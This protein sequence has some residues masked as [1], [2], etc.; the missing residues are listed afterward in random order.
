[1]NLPPD[2]S[3]VHTRT[4]DVLSRYPKR[5]PPLP[6]AYRDIY[7]QHY[8]ANRLASYHTT[9]LSQRLEAWMHHQVASDLTTA[10]YVSTLE[11]GAGTLNHL[12]FA[13]ATG[14]YDIVEP[15]AKLYEDSPQLARIGSIYQ[16]IRDV[17]MGKTYD[18]IVSIATFEHLLDL[19]AVVAETTRLLAPGGTLRVA[20][21]NEGTLLWRL[22]TCVTGTEFRLRYG[23]NYQVLMRHEH[24][25]TAA[26]VKAVLQHAYS[27]LRDVA[28][29]VSR[30]LALYRF[31][32]CRR[33]VVPH[34]AAA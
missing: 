33:P 8:V 22:G 25:N 12:R 16:D 10:G 20:I 15:F 31:F 2:H 34:A 30:G 3:L 1:M 9:S 27:D 32:E 6:Q 18:R 26:E 5:R 23:L 4:M 14:D 24:V 19:P 11:I 7:E 17:P 13:P 29:G 28:C 21:P